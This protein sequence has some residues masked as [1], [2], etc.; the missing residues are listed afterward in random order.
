MGGFPYPDAAVA[1]ASRARHAA[2]RGAGARVR[3]ARGDPE[4]G[5]LL[6]G[7]G[8]TMGASAGAAG[9]VPMSSRVFSG[10]RVA[11]GPG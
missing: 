8:A 6:V 2:A 1:P 10:R 3:P 5:G 9:P 7:P 11:V 4:T